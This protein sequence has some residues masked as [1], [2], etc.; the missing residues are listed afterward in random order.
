MNFKKNLSIL[1][2]LIAA[3][4]I[5]VACGAAAAEGDTPNLDAIRDRGYLIVGVFGETPPFGYVDQAGVS[6]GRDPFIARRL[7]YELLGDEN[8]IQ[9]VITE[10]ANR[11]PFLLSYNVDVIVANFT[12][13]EERQEQ[14]D[15]SLP[16]AQVALGIVGDRA[17]GLTSVYDLYGQDL[18]VTQGTTSEIYFTQN[19]PEINLVIFGQNT[20]SFNALL[21]GRAPAMAHDNT[22]LFPFQFQNEDRF[23]MV[24][25]NLGEPQYL[26]PAIR[27]NNHDL[28]DWLNE[29]TLRLREEGFFYE[30]FDQ[31]LAPYFSPDTNPSDVMVN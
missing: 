16:Y 14:V 21:D 10:A 13:T 7:A 11:I 18:I 28:L 8:A 5:L 25:G 30:V 15:F 24:T 29:T 2:T 1:A 19:H 31:T 23:E 6:V 27:Q 20:E 4:F 9:F 26:A 22:L 12:I 17:A 3:A